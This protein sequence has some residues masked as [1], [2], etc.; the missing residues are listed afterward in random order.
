[1][2]ITMYDNVDA[3]TIPMRVRW[4]PKRYACAGYVDGSWGYSYGQMRRR[5]PKSNVLSITGQ[6]NVA[7]CL[8]IEPGNP[9]YAGNAWQWVESMHRHGIARPCI[10]ASHDQMQQAVASL[11]RHGIP[12]GKYRLWLAHWTYN[13]NDALAEL[14]DWDAV[15]WTNHSIGGCDESVCRDNFFGPVIT[16]KPRPKRKPHPK[17]TAVALAGAMTTGLQA[18]LHAKGVAHWVPTPAEGSAITAA[19]AVLAGYLR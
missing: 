1:M 9:F 3:A 19:A 13:R 4:Y 11:E 6:G 7:Q 17:I 15:Q 12:R 16:P 10:Y 14:R 8:D 2:P 5:F 18:L